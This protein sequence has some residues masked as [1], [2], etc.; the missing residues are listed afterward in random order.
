MLWRTDSPRSMECSHCRRKT[1]IPCGCSSSNERA[2]NESEGRISL[3]TESKILWQNKITNAANNLRN[4]A[5]K[6]MVSDCILLPRHADAKCTKRPPTV[7]K[8]ATTDIPLQCEAILCG[9]MY[10]RG[11]APDPEFPRIPRSFARLHVS[12]QTCNGN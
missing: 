10:S 3:S 9:I 6:T 7:Q 11:T 4:P 8:A 1:S 5:I 12:S 2:I